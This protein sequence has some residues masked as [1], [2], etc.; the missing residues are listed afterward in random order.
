MLSLTGLASK[1]GSQAAHLAQLTPSGDAWQNESSASA[2]SLQVFNMLGE[3][4]APKAGRTA[5]RLRARALE[6]DRP[7]ARPQLPA[8]RC[9]TLSLTY[10]TCKTGVVVGPLPQEMQIK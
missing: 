1:P 7:E 8:S 3:E 10:L 2:S 6:P 9:T 5:Q 4:A